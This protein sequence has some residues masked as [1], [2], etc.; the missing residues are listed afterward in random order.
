M[1]VKIHDS[2]SRVSYCFIC[3]GCNREHAF[4]TEWKPLSNRSEPKWVFNGNV[5]RPTFKPSLLYNAG[6]ANPEVDLCHSY[7][8]DGRIQFLSDCTH[9]LA[10]KTVD[11]PEI[12]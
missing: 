2:P 11:L 1:R 12:K 5:D 6:R 7:V 4:V 10:N 9:P 8:T 3:P